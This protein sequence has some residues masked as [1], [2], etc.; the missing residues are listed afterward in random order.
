VRIDALMKGVEL[1]IAPLIQWYETNNTIVGIIPSLMFVPIIDF[2]LVSVGIFFFG[3][4]V[5]KWLS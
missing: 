5:L 1:D 3:W 4:I 2:I